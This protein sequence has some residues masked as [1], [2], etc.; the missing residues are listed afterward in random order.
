[1]SS[2]AADPAGD[3]LRRGFRASW[4]NIHRIFRGNLHLL[5]GLVDSGNA[6][7]ADAP[8]ADHVATMPNLAKAVIVSA[9]EKQGQQPSKEKTEQIKAAL[10]QQMM[11]FS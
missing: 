2:S 8:E 4:R 5:A 3:T 6:E 9:A 1:M 11:D 10:G 7:E